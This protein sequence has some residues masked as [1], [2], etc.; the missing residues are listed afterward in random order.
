MRLSLWKFWSRFQTRLPWN[1]FLIFSIRYL[2]F[3]WLY[4]GYISLKYTYKLASFAIYKYKMQLIA[5]F[6]NMFK[7][8]IW[9]NIHIY[10]TLTHGSERGG[11][12][13]CIVI[14]LKNYLRK[15]LLVFKYCMSC[16]LLHDELKIFKHKIYKLKIFYVSYVWL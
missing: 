10:F 12:A 9:I 4:I 5:H 7:K 2:V 16:Y 15:Y 1:A 3:F 8:Y 6:P 14:C 13:A 11:M